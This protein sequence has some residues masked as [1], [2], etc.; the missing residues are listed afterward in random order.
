MVCTPSEL[1]LSSPPTAEAEW[2]LDTRSCGKACTNGWTS[3]EPCDTCESES[4]TLQ[5]ALQPD[6]DVPEEL[7]GQGAWVDAVVQE[8]QVQASKGAA[9][10]SAK[11]CGHVWTNI[12]HFQMR[13]RIKRAWKNSDFNVGFRGSQTR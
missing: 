7:I 2:H 12:K 5:K 8:A 3:V 13:D 4:T 11:P 6:A 1:K 10:V 9:A